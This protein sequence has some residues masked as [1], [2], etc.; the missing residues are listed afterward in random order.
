VFE[1]LRPRLIA[2]R[3]EDGKEL[4]DIEDAPRPNAETPVPPRF[5]PQFDNVLLSHAD[6]S[7][8]VPAGIGERIY[9]R[10]GHWSPLLV[11]GRLRGTWK[12]HRERT[13]AALAIELGDSL[14]KRERAAVEQEGETLLAFAAAAAPR[15]ELRFVS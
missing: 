1:R 3:D 5:L 14:T 11:G 13:A 12:L 6:R 8:I 7:R 10:H 4:F 2:F 15:R 9:R